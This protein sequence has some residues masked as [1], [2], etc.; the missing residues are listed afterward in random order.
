MKQVERSWH[1]QKHGNMEAQ[2]DTPET[3]NLPRFI[4]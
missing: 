4:K 2:L 3:A 1:D